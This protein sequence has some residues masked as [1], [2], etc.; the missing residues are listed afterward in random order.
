MRTP[1]H[2]SALVLAAALTLAAAAAPPAAG[3]VVVDG[4]AAVVNGEVITLLELEKAGKL[5]VETRLRD[6]PA[7]EHERA[8]REVLLPILDQLVLVRLQRQLARRLGVQVSEQEVDAAIANVLQDNRLS[9]E[10]LE[11]LLRERG[12][13]RADYRREIADKIRLSKLVKIEITGKLTVSDDEIAAWFAGHRQEWYRPARI[14]IRHLLV[15]LPKEPTADEEAAAQAKI[16]ALAAQARGGADFAALVRSQDPGAAP[17]A[18]PVTGEI[19]RGELFPAL[20]DAAFALPAGGVS[21]PVRSPAGFHLVQVAEKTPAHEPTLAE[22]R[23][24]IEQRLLELKT[25]DR[26]ESWLKQ[27]RAAATVEIRY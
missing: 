7:A 17:D 21:E 2:A 15:P 9:D 25:R 3:A 6:L 20:E 5:E 14:R 16:D 8:R 23:G 18:D 26:Y 22:M 12:M 13:S 1:R 27:L 24:S 19:T 11:R 4:I 10:V